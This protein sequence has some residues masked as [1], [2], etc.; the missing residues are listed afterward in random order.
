MVNIWFDLRLLVGGGRPGGGR[1]GGGLS[2]LAGCMAGHQHRATMTDLSRKRQRSRT[3]G[4]DARAASPGESG[5]SPL[6]PQPPAPPMAAKRLGNLPVHAP[7]FA[8][9]PWGLLR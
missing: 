9:W 2:Q 8:T 3:R 7:V 6:T 4:V 5:P 1:G